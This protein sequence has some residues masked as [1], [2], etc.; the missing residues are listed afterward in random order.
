M[1]QYEVHAVTDV[2]G[3]GLLGHA[4]EMANGA[5]VGLRIVKNQVPVL[6]GAREL[7]EQGV[8]PGGSKNNF[9]HVK[10]MVSFPEEMDQTDRYLLCDAVTS[11][12]L[13]MSVAADD[14]E[15]LLSELKEA[16][17]E[18]GMIGE[19]MESPVDRVI[20]E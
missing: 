11:G 16:G 3:F 8:L 12:G 17:L 6:E 2:T 4:T 20:V 15:K 13:L 9:N 5:H 1:S 7:A 10:D 14:A 18:A 19:V